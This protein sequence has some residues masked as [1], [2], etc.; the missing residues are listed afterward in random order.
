MESN[1]VVWTLTK[2]IYYFNMIKERYKNAYYNIAKEIS[3]LS[4]ANRLKVG[5][6]IV[7][8]NRII[9][10]GFNGTPPN[11]DNEC[12]E[13]E[14]FYTRS[15]YFKGQVYTY[16]SH[17]KDINAKQYTR[18]KT[19]PEVIHAEMNALHKLASSNE[20]GNNATMFCTHTPC[21]ECAKGVVMSGIKNFYYI[22]K[23]RSDDGLF[24][25]Q[26]SGVNIEQRSYD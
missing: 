14:V 26:K 7:K 9:S 8:D 21:M 3:L 12:E 22:D 15:T 23:Y 4:Y 13:E 17:I 20:S 1:F 11:W 10:I 24:F 5:A 2:W 25:L 16:E 6:I 18:L 19:K